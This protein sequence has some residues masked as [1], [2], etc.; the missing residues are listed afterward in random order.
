MNAIE[1][2]MK[3]DAK[4]GSILEFI[5]EEKSRKRKLF[6]QVPLLWVLLALWVALTWSTFHQL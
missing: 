1:K 5:L 3:R 4:P 6:R 2:L